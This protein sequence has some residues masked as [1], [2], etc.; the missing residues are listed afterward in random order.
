MD[1]ASVNPDQ[2]MNEA[3]ADAVAQEGSPSLSASGETLRFGHRIALTFDDGPDPASTPAILDILRER[4]I[5]A[6]FFVIG[7]RAERYPELVRRMV[8]EGHTLGNHTYHHEDM[9]VLTPDSMRK[10]IRET[11]AAVERASGVRHRISLFRPPCGAPYLTETD[12]LPEFQDLMREQK[13]YPVM[14]NIDPR[15]WSYEG[16]PGLVV[17]SVVQSTPEDGGVLLLHDTQ[18]QTAAALPEILNYYASAGFGF[19]GVREM[20]AEKYGV[21][22]NGI[23]DVSRAPAPRQQTAPKP[24]V[25]EDALSSA[26]CLTY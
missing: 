23:E 12:R 20:L 10:E 18:P 14:W 1:K 15:D 4:N 9:T 5:K 26:D 8:E 6:T 19:T 22:A 7:D 3:W 11:Q 24:D 16:S 25:A 21:S 17:D 2:V 13:M